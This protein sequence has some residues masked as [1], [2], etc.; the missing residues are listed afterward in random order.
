MLPT[1]HLVPDVGICGMD[2]HV[3]GT[4]THTT[5]SLYYVIRGGRKGEKVPIQ[6]GK[7][8]IF[9][10]D[11]ERGSQ[12]LWKLIDETKNTMILMSSNWELPSL[13]F[14]CKIKNG[15]K[16]ERWA[17]RRERRNRC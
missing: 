3:Q 1:E 10:F 8:I 15:E 17:Q 16:I 2:R 13:S 11:I 14:L 5:D 9:V 12:A 4:E 7:P 6:K